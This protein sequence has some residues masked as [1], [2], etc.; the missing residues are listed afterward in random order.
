[1]RS[2]AISSGMQAYIHTEHCIHSKPLNKKY[3]NK[4]M[5]KAPEEN[6]FLRFKDN[7]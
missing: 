5:I 6:Y 2:G 7:L 1:M 3:A 4:N